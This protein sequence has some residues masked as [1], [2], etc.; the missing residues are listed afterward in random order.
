M[1]TAQ[2]QKYRAAGLCP[3]C[4][5]QPEEGYKYC[6]KCR[7]KWK[8]YRERRDAIYRRR[9]GLL[10]NTQYQRKF[11]E[12]RKAA[13][14]CPE[15][16]VPLSGTASLCSSCMEKQREVGRA[17]YQRHKEEINRRRREAGYKRYREDKAAGRCPKCH[18]PLPENCATSYCPECLE[19]RRGLPVE[20][21]P[22]RKQY[23]REYY[24]KNREKINAYRRAYYARNRAI[25]LAYRQEH[26]DKIRKEREDA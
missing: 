9:T 17:W 5:A 14:L 12:K 13:G 16:G 20:S 1:T 6:A 11:R 3:S 8:E 24:E 2:T 15:C 4:G 22:E 19:K 25:I 23:R 10:Y 21:T 18:R 7:A 26:G